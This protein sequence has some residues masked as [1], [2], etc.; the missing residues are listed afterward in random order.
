MAPGP[1]LCMLDY[2]P[3]GPIEE[4]DENGRVNLPP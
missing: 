1:A 4:V 3:P 2:C